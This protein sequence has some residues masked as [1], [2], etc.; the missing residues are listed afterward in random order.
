MKK[1]TQP[2]GVLLRQLRE[3]S[4]FSLRDLEAETGISNSYLSQIESGRVGAPSP[5]ILEKLAAALKYPYV[6]LMR[7]AGH[8][9]IDLPVE[10]V[11]RL[12]GKEHS[13]AELT[14]SERKEVV[15]FIEQLKSKRIGRKE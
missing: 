15:R 2:F 6:E 13:L 9:T 14:S 3:R 8:L 1:D 10:P 5:K 7:G 11:L 4:E 12:G